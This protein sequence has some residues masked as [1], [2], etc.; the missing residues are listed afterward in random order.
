MRIEISQVKFVTTKISMSQQIAQQVTK[1]REEKFVA[2]KENYV[3]I[4]IVQES[5]KSCRDR[6]D[7][8]LDQN[9]I[10]TLSKFVTT[11][12]SEKAQ[13]TGRNRKLYATIEASDKD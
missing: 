1:T 10:V 3:A 13:R 7:K 12:S 4:E 6:L 8:L 9:S 11:E 2:T 5:K